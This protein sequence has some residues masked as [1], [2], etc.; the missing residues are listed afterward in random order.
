MSHILD[1]EAGV[2][3][4]ANSARAAVESLSHKASASARELLRAAS[5]MASR[6]R[7]CIAI[8]AQRRRE[9]LELLECLAQDRRAAADMRVSPEAEFWARQPFWR[10]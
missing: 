6:L 9:R 8:W 3:L 4:R 2:A 7:E 5:A 1:I 10:P